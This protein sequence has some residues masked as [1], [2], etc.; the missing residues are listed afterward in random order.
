MRYPQF[1]SPGGRIGFI[2]PSFGCS[3][4]PYRSAFAA[5][6]KHFQSL[7]Y[8]T[9]T[10][11]NCYADR[12]VGKS[13]TPEACGAEINDF[14]LNDRA[15]VIISCGGGETMCE[16]LPYADLSAIA[17]AKPHW[18]MGYSDNTNLTFILPTVCDTAAVYGP[19]ASSFGM[20]PLHPSLEDAFAVLTGEKTV[21]TNYSGWEKESLRDEEHPCVP[22]QITEPYGMSVAGGGA[23]H[24]RGRL[25]GGCLDCL[26]TLCGTRFDRAADFAERY[27]EDGIVWFLEACDLNPMSMRRA[28]WQ[29]REAGWFRHAA[30]FIFGRPMHFG[31][32]FMG[33]GFDDAATEVLGSLNVPILL[34]AD[35][36]HL[37][38]MMPLIVGSYASVE[39]SGNDMEIRMSF[40]RSI[41]CLSE[42]NKRCKSLWKSIIWSILWTFCVRS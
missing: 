14:F 28:L 1:L 36:G 13:N 20:Q 30:G 4:E 11:P 34:N 10:G 3:M 39:V 15:D 6:L 16:D 21:F 38:P 19:C 2:A 40:E 42:A 37:P 12:G 24:F 8:R 29:L 35:L 31:E 9:V 23:A 25:I 27:K 22:Y 17:A 26:V 7:G 5:A 41:P 33:M 18:Y 32:T